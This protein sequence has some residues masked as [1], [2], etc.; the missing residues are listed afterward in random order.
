M[1]GE[2]G[3]AHPVFSCR[4]GQP[5]DR[6]AVRRCLYLAALAIART[7]KTPLAATNQ[8][9]RDKGK[10]PKLALVATMRKLLITLNAMIKNNT[11]FQYS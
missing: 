7:G 5:F 8:R 11:P 3:G 4:E 1:H 10:P 2:A 6:P 9:L